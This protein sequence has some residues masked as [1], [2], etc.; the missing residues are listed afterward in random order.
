MSALPVN[1]IG[2]AEGAVPAPGAT[3][4]AS[5]A[6]P[7]SAFTGGRPTVFS[8]TVAPSPGS[9]LNP[10]M[11]AALGPD[12]H[13]LPLRHGAPFIAGTHAF[14]MTYFLDAQPG[15][16]T[17]VVTGRNQTSGPFTARIALPGD[18]TGLGNV[19]LADLRAFARTFPASA[20][21]AFYKP[22]ADANLNGIIGHGDAAFLERNLTPLTPKKPLVVELHLAPGEQVLH[23]RVHNSGGITRTANITILGRTAPGSI[24]FADDALGN[25]SFSGA[26]IATDAQGNFQYPFHLKDQLTNFE[27]LVIDPYGQRTVRAFPVLMI[28]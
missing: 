7:A 20:H 3:G 8:V 28:Q 9:T 5:V 4:T 11:V 25:Y 16:A 1:T 22:S 21:D 10:K 14:A 24:V 13:K 26:A 17:A 6:I 15:L 19:N 27:F 12:G 18:V 2:V 23:P